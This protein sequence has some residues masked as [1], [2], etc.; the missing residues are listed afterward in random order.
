[1]KIKFLLITGPSGVGKSVVISELKNIDERFVY[2]SPYMTRPLRKYE[3]D[4]ISISESKLR[5]MERNGDFLVVNELYGVLYGTP[6]F[7]INNAFEKKQFPLID[8]P[9]SRTSIMEKNFPN[10]LFTTYLEPPSIECLHKRLKGRNNSQKRFE[11]GKIEIDD[12][13]A[14][15][16][17][18]IIDLKII[19]KDNA[20]IPIANEIYKEYLKNN[21]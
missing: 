8:W 7:S 20:I 1:M 18:G 13:N 3:F 16:F 10:Q 4:K 5:D 2:I 19:S 11:E 17:N 14:G 9:I 6:K 12:L 21:L 15:K